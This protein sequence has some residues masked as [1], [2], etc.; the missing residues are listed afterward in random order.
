MRKRMTWAAVQRL[1]SELG[2]RDL[3]ILADVG[4]VRLLTGRQVERLH[5]AGL[6]GAH[7]DRARRRA[8]ERLTG[9]HRTTPGG[10]NRQRRAAKPLQ[11]NRKRH[12]MVPQ[13]IGRY[14]H[15]AALRVPNKDDLDLV[16][17][18]DGGYDRRS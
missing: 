11:G 4:R 12:R 10:I 13:D 5:F 14:W 3:A 9:L 16:S 15:F 2:R 8:L 7:R 18:V 1:A 6:S 17:Y